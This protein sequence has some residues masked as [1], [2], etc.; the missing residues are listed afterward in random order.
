MPQ[1]SQKC[2]ARMDPHDQQECVSSRQRLATI[3][4]R[5]E[6]V[7]PFPSTNITAHGTRIIKLHVNHGLPARDWP[8]GRGRPRHITI[9][10]PHQAENEVPQPH[11]FVA[12]GFTK[13][14]P[15]CISVS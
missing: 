6:S 4:V 8:R 13:T 14:K 9:M 2:A 12:C 1:D 11:D 10:I 3:A 7:I 15:C 5:A